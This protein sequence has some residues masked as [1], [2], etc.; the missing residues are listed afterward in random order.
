MLAGI[1]WAVRSDRSWRAM[2]QE[3]GKRET[4]DKRSRSGGATGLWPRILAARPA[5][6]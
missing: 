6:G 4:A 3:G 5:G 1:R 2:S